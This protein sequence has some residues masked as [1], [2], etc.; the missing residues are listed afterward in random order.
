MPMP[1]DE[2][3]NMINKYLNEECIDPEELK[4]KIQDAMN[5]MDPNNSQAILNE[6][7]IDAQNSEKDAK[8][9]K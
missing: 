6:I 1:S 2:I 3:V 8:K 9:T 7:N 5:T 4:K